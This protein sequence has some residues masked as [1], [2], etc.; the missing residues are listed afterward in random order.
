MKF[1]VTVRETLERVVVIEAESRAEAEQI[2]EDKWVGSEFILD[3]EDFV[4]ASFEA[5]AALN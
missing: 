5:K 1:E 3:A 4:G 2:A